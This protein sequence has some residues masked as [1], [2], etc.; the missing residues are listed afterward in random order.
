MT[1]FYSRLARY[2]DQMYSFIDYEKNAKTLNE[3]IQRYKKAPDTRLL[4]VACGTGTHLKYLKNTYQVMGFDISNEMLE[5]ADKKCPDIEFIQGDM[6]SMSLDRKFDVITCLFGS[7]N[8]LVKKADLVK[9]IHAFSKH[10]V[11]GGLVIIEPIFTTDSYREGSLGILCVDL[12]EIK[13]ARTNVT[14]R[15]GDIAYLDFHFLIST[16]ETGTEHFVDPSPMGIF[17]KDM[18]LKMMEESG[19]SASFVEP[20]L[21]KEGLFIGIK[22]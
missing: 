22:K 7:I 6:T 14:R 19:L 1:D 3:I 13:I 20:G 10:L 2:Y 8:Y 11:T 9:A 15:E 16:P 5:I 18:F 4:D 21:A 17:S 12:P